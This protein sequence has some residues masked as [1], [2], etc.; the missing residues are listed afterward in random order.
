MAC[1]RKL[2]PGWSFSENSALL[3]TCTRKLELLGFFLPNDIICALCFCFATLSSNQ[4]L[5]NSGQNQNSAGFTLC[6]RIFFFYMCP[7]KRSSTLLLH[8]RR[9]MAFS[10]VLL[11]LQFSV[12]FRSNSVHTQD[13]PSCCAIAFV[14]V[15]VLKPR[16]YIAISLKIGGFGE[17][18][19]SRGQKLH[20]CNCDSPVLC[21]SQP[22]GVIKTN[23]LQ[24][25]GGRS[26]RLIKVCSSR[27]LALPPLL[28]SCPSA[29]WP[30]HNCVFVTQRRH[31]RSFCLR[32]CT[33]HAPNSVAVILYV[34]AG[35]SRPLDFRNVCG[36][37]QV[38]T[39]ITGPLQKKK[40]NSIIK[41]NWSCSSFCLGPVLNWWFVQCVLPP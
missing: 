10:C 5:I 1:F 20:K 40:R 15:H 22:G 26:L 4:Q 14:V 6:S 25:R 11:T 35:S 2:P 21:W 39:K 38:R 7:D 37:T 27:L 23:F 41:N 32:H 3:F 17:F 30:P 9:Q 29:T 8:W 18:S 34:A 12:A 24:L 19:K 13:P 31:R 36:Q 16:C 33:H 28:C